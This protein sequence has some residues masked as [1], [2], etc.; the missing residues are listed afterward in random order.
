MIKA[1]SLFM[2]LAFCSAGAQNNNVVPTDPQA[3]Q[4]I[5]KYIQASGGEALLGIKTEIHK[6]TLV[7]GKQGKVPLVVFAKAPNKWRYNQ[8]FAWG[9][10]I[11]Y[12]FDGKSAWMADTAGVGQ[13]DRRQQFDFQLIFDLQAPLRLNEIY[14]DM[15]VAG[16]ESFA[17]K[18]AIKILARSPQ[19]FSTELVF[20][21]ETGLLLRAGK[22]YFDDYRPVGELVRPYKITLGEA[23]A[24][25]PQLTIQFDEISHNANLEDSLFTQ[26]ACPLARGIPPLHKNRNP[27]ELEIQSLDRLVGVY[28]H[29]ADSNITFTI[30]RQD[31]HLM[32]GM[33]GSGYKIEI[34]PESETDFFIMFPD[35]EFHFL[36][37]SLGNI[38]HLVFGPDSTAAGPKIK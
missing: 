17:G 16:R 15:K 11:E 21:P 33:T 30:S 13:M 3:S 2:I 22:I 27:V 36:Q 1:L 20:D 6:G 9:D 10:R 28:R 29:P 7:R 37:D 4:I 38:T 12:G 19:G 18:E 26:P 34:K 14:P 8:L 23:D 25:Q 32:I 24:A 5:D 31:I 35:Q